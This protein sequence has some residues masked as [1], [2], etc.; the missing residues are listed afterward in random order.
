MTLNVAG[1]ISVVKRKRVGRLIKQHIV[2]VVC[3]QEMHVKAGEGKYLTQ[4]F[5]GHIFHSFAT[6]RARGVL[7]GL[8]RVSWVLKDSIVDNMGRIFMIIWKGL[9]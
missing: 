3:L 9:V 2:D 5:S 7:V 4:V 1:L 8:S 6:S